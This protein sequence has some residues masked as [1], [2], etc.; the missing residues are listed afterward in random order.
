M[1]IGGTAK[2]AL[3]IN[4]SQNICASGYIIEKYENGKWNR[5]A[6]IADANT[7]TYRVENLKPESTY[8]F[9]IKA[10]DFDGSVP[11]YSEYQNISGK[12][13]SAS[14]TSATVS[15]VTGVKIGGRA[16]DALRINWNKVNGTSGY[17]IEK[18]ENG[19]W[20]RI[21]RIADA[22]TQTYR[23]EGLKA[24]TTYKFRIEAFSFS[25]KTPLYS[26]YAYINGRTNPAVATGVCIGGT[27]KDALRV[28]W[29]KVNGASGY[30]IEKYDNG[31]WIRVARIAD[32]NTQTYRV[33]KLKSN[34]AYV[35]RVRSFDFDGSTPLYSG[36]QYVTG[37]TL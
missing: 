33:E 1:K 13:N 16:A 26:T 35:F 2:D 14:N 10:F 6:R 17:I 24:S 37:S 23:V 36:S 29:N 8:N 22:N 31:N 32:A 20:I 21:A 9:R 30:I 25:G 34:T 12:T 27:A 3:R 11:I 7:T 19:K 28:N 15:N 18:Y 4:W 5:I